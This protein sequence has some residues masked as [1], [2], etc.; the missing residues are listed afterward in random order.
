MNAYRADLKSRGYADAQVDAA[1]SKI[2]GRNKT[3]GR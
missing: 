2:L 3:V 1:M